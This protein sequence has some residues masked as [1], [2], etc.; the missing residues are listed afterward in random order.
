MN[1]VAVPWDP[2]VRV[3]EDGEG[4]EEFACDGVPEGE[5]LA[6]ETLGLVFCAEEG[7]VVVCGWTGVA[8]E[9]RCFGGL[10]VVVD[11]GV[12]EGEYGSCE[13]GRGWW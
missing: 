13:G 6:E 3:A 11:F 8:G 9:T 10:L 1:V 5:G 4:A 12:T 7:E 2:A